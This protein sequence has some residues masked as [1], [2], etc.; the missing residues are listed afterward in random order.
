MYCFSSLLRRLSLT[1]LFCVMVIPAS[2]HALTAPIASEPD[3]KEIPSEEKEVQPEKLISLTSL[4]E[5]SSFFSAAEKK[6]ISRLQATPLLRDFALILGSGGSEWRTILNQR[7]DQPIQEIRSRQSINKITKAASDR[8]SDIYITFSRPFDFNALRQAWLDKDVLLEV[9]SRGKIIPIQHLAQESSRVLRVGFDQNQPLEEAALITVGIHD[10]RKNPTFAISYASFVLKDR[11]LPTLINTQQT[12]SG[13]FLFEF[14]EPIYTGTRNAGFE[15]WK[16]NGYKIYGSL[17]QAKPDTAESRLSGDFRRFAVLE[18]N[19]EGRGHYRP[20][21]EINHLEG[22]GI[23]DYAGQQSGKRLNGV[24]IM[25]ASPKP[26][27]P[28]PEF[29][30]QSPEQFAL[31]F[32]SETVSLHGW[33]MPLQNEAIRVERQSGWD[34]N[35]NPKW[36]TEHVR[37]IEDIAV[38]HEDFLTYYLHLKKDWSR[39]LQG[40]DGSPTYNTPGYNRI[41]IT[42]L[43]GKAKDLGSGM[44]NQSDIM[45]EFTLLA[46]TQLPRIA[47]IVPA[48]SAIP[49]QETIEATFDKPVQIPG[50]SKY[51]TPPHGE[52]GVSSPVFEFVSTQSKARIQTSVIG[53]LTSKDNMTYTLTLPDEVAQ[54]PGR[55]ELIVHNLSDDVGNKSDTL[56]H[57]V[58]IKDLILRPH[59]RMESPALIWGTAIDNV[60]AD[61]TTEAKE[62]VVILQFNTIL[63]KDALTREKYWIAG[64]QLP[65]TAKILASSVRFDMDKDGIITDKDGSGTRVT[66]L[67]PRETFG[68]QDSTVIAQP[69]SGVSFNVQ[70][71]NEEGRQ[72]NKW[73]SLPYNQSGTPEVIPEEVYTRYRKTEASPSDYAWLQEAIQHTETELSASHAG[74]A[75]GEF[76]TESVK[77]LQRAIL[78]AKQT[79][80]KKRAAR[81]E[82]DGAIY[83][84][85][86]ARID[87]Y[88]SQHALPADKWKLITQLRIATFE[89]EEIKENP[90]QYPYALH[91]TFAE[92]IAHAEAVVANKNATEQEIYDAYRRLVDAINEKAK[93]DHSYP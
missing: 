14:D 69:I 17:T 81:G 13:T 8:A 57:Y 36:T 12:G 10:L 54:H 24:K 29:S 47:K 1:L 92:A 82:I 65:T 45:H 75:E 48:F 60:N 7:V 23:A 6:G 63:S 70:V 50:A 58:M 89:W 25:F 80:R 77:A 21:G 26:T 71:A 86:T 51:L 73:G 15:F 59:K 16:M 4:K 67:L 30:M 87:F 5:L 11:K 62:D 88:A 32:P 42:L 72:I 52:N 66:I 41:R 3:K 34:E 90:Y 53:F 74:D 55:W 79:A 18:L 46:D 9:T 35:G 91:D 61:L 39:I 78:Q 28:I 64:K 22:F 83:S 33:G 56:T 93:Y 84:L 19:Y 31:R 49:G 44:S 43:R 40:E 38:E 76:P 27:E 68:T 2:V 20:P 85:H 37:L